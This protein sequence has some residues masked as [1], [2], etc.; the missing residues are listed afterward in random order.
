M[1]GHAVARGGNG[2][3]QVAALVLGHGGAGDRGDIRCSP[4]RRATRLVPD[5]C[6]PA[7][8]TWRCPFTRPPSDPA[9]PPS[10]SDRAFRNPRSSQATVRSARARAMP[11]ASCGGARRAAASPST[12]PAATMAPHRPPR[13]GPRS[14]AITGTSHD[15]AS[16][17]TRPKGSSHAGVTTSARAS[18]VRR[19]RSPDRCPT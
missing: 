2:A 16:A 6:S 19:S 8:K 17:A 7:T 4:S 15:N 10:P 13:P 14:N 11:A 1:T 18:A 3:L 5:R 12:S 9:P